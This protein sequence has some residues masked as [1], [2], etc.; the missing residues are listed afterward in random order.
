MPT[1]NFY[2]RD[3]SSKD[4]PAI[5]IETV[6]YADFHKRSETSY[7]DVTI[8]AADIP[9]TSITKRDGTVVNFGD[10]SISQF[11][12]EGTGIINE[13]TTREVLSG[14][15]ITTPVVTP[16]RNKGDDLRYD[17]YSR[18]RFD[19][20]QTTNSTVSLIDG[21]I[22]EGLTIETGLIQNTYVAFSGNIED[23]L[24]DID[25]NTYEGLAEDWHTN[26][27][28]SFEN[29]EY[30]DNLTDKNVLSEPSTT[31]S[32]GDV[33]VNVDE[34]STET[35]EINN[36]YTYDETK[37]G[38]DV[39]S[40][41][42]VVTNYVGSYISTYDSFNVQS[43]QKFDEYN[44]ALPVD[45]NWRGYISN[46]EKTIFAQYT[47]IHYNNVTNDVFEKSYTFTLGLSNPDTGL[48]LDRKT[49]TLVVQASPESLS[50]DY[51]ASKYVNVDYTKHFQVFQG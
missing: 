11:V 20:A 16:S 3:T 29:I 30:I 23:D 49:F 22:P 6:N 13:A 19:N 46:V 33:V 42:P 18:I 39:D 2:I 15:P 34:G 48:E 8:T 35:R 31:F 26:Q 1:V 14:A 24:F 38:I 36:I 51:L 47:D 21:S 37:I 41:V 25:T 43:A 10:A 44:N 32:L 27:Q 40:F 12:T 7:P 17:W 4:L 5:L 28:V 50:D 45:S 9:V